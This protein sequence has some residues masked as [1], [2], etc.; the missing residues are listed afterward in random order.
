[1][2]T[3]WKLRDDFEAWVKNPHMLNRRTE[4]GYTDDYEN[5]WTDGAWAAWQEMHDRAKPPVPQTPI[6]RDQWDDACR[7]LGTKG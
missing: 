6:T 5:P 2:S 7:G 1:M 4:P 3:G